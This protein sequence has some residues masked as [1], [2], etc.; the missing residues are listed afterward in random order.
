MAAAERDNRFAWTSIAIFVVILTAISTVWHFAIVGL[1]P[2]SIYVG[3]LMW[4]PAIAAFLT[5]KITGHEIYPQ[6]W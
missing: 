5:L 1:A 3:A 4:S 6:G 2:V